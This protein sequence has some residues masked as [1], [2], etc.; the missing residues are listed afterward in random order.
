MARGEQLCLVLVLL[1]SRSGPAQKMTAA[2]FAVTAPHG[3]RDHPSQAHP[4]CS[5]LEQKQML[6]KKEGPLELQGGK[7]HSQSWPQQPVSRASISPCTSTQ[8]LP[9]SYPAALSEA[10]RE[11]G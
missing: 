4:I 1:C 3:R 11:S 6:C 10:A 7:P 9:S 5:T 8:L 2:A